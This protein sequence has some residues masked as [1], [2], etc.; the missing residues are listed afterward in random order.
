MLNAEY[1]EGRSA[2]L[3]LLI[4]QSFDLRWLDCERVIREIYVRTAMFV[5]Y[6]EHVS[7]KSAT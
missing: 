1:K 3:V 7:I 6:K 5:S 4:K 2:I